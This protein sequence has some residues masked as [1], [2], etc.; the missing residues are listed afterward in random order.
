MRHPKQLWTQLELG[1]LNSN[2]GL[3]FIC[4][5]S[6]LLFMIKRN[7]ITKIVFLCGVM[8]AYLQNQNEV[9]VDNHVLD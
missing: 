1:N 4:R 7:K 3:T 9:S 6:I 5:K 8:F 2:L